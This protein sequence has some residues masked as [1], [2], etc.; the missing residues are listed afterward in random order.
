MRSLVLIPVLLLAA[1]DLVPVA[2]TATYD[3]GVAAS[4]DQAMCRLGF[5]AVPMTELPSGHHLVE[6]ILN[7]KPARFVVDTGAN[8]TVLHAPLV[9]EY[10]LERAL[11]AAAAVG[12]GGQAKAGLWRYQTLKIGAVET[13]AGRIISTDLGQMVSVLG[14]RPDQPIVG[15]IGQDV[16]S[17]QQAVIDVP[18]PILYL[19]SK[20]APSAVDPASCGA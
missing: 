17:A 12:L 16:L 8:A 15:I 13:P 2:R 5:T 6:A 1:C 18:R 11:G 4:V 3:P 14:A 10:G 20:G 19:R 9:A 7:G